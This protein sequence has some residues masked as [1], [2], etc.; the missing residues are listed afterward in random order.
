[1]NDLAIGTIVGALVGDAAGATLEFYHQ[2]ITEEKARKAMRMPGGGSLNVGPGQITDD[3]E[4]TLA[5]A[6]ALSKNG[7]AY[8]E[9][10]VAKAYVAWHR[11]D[12][13]DMGQTT[14]RAFAF[15]NSA[16]E[17]RANALKYNTLSEANGQLMRCTPIP[18][19]LYDK[20][21]L[22][23]IA[24]ITRYDTLLSH[25]NEACGDCAALYCVAIAYLI[26]HPGD[27]EGA[28]QRVRS[29]PVSAKVM[30]WLADS[31]KPLTELADCRINAGHVRHAFTLAFHFLRKK[32]T[33][34]DAVRETLKLGGDT[35]TNACI[36]GGM[37]GALHGLS[38]IPKY[39]V[40]PVMKFDPTTHDAKKTL[41]GYRRP[42][43]YRANN[44]LNL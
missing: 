41:M 40:D 11:S 16:A 3:G 33:Y 30:G 42:A 15:A 36:V 13:F 31:S 43:A 25:P 21:T 9:D 38:E 35:D 19:F 44:V 4:L 28:I 8:I 34:E 2:K 22:A 32:N 10:E 37:V 26:D 24:E 12:P 14:S 5:L 39:M 7:G 29:I 18:A 1:M 6:S 23:E 17:M 27:A 20:K